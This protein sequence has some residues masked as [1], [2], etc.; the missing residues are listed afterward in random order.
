MQQFE[1]NIMYT[2]SYDVR[3][4][5]WMIWLVDSEMK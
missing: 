3:V 4:N 5:Q 2:K 1:E